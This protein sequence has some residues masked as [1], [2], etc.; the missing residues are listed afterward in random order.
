MPLA[1]TTHAVSPEA[2]RTPSREPG[3]P[4]SQ[5][6]SEAQLDKLRNPLRRPRRLGADWLRRRESRAHSAH[7]VTSS[8]APGP[9]PSQ[10]PSE[11]YEGIPIM[12]SFLQIAIGGRGRH[13]S[14]LHSSQSEP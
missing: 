8:W 3:P 14:G 9:P 13:A 4:S 7:L 11:A 10:S 12:Q 1:V 5:S 6:A 2:G